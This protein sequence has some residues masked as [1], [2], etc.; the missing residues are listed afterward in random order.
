VSATILAWWLGIAVLA[1]IAVILVLALALRT[2][3]RIA[4]Q[5]AARAAAAD[6]ETARLRSAYR[7]TVAQLATRVV[8]RAGERR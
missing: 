1:A 3:L 5:E 2:T 6:A 7:S 4:H 8:N